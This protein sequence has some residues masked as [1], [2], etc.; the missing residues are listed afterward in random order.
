MN[1][2]DVLQKC[3]HLKI[4]QKNEI[5]EDYVERVFL[6][7]DLGKWEKVLTDCLGPAVKQAGEKTTEEF[8]ELTIAYGGLLD[9]Q[10]LYY[11][12]FQNTSVAVLFL[13]VPSNLIKSSS[14]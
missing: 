14:F 1:V 7:E 9:D 10:I 2:S 3:S 13:I 4:E 8:S 11:K 5:S 6:K 12:E